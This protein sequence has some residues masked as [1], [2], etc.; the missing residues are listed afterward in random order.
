[1]MKIAIPCANGALCMHF[2]HCQEF[3]IVSVEETNKKIEKCETMTPPAHEPGLLPK[4]LA[5][6][7]ATHVIAGGMGMR[8]QQL[9]TQNGIEVVT[10]APALPPEEIVSAYMNGTLEQGQ[11]ACDH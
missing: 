10:G 3:A 2:G 1:M 6:Q 5:E 7:N 11:N 9:F 8:A 4:W